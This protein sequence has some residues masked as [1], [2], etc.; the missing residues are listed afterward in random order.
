MRFTMNHLITNSGIWICLICML[1]L[2][3]SAAAGEEIPV[4]KEPPKTQEAEKSKPVVALLVSDAQ[5]DAD[6]LLPP[7]M[8]KLGKENEWEIV[9]LHGHGTADFP[10]FDVLEKTDVLIVYIR[11]LA[12][13]KEQLEKLK[14]YAKS[15]RGVIGL[16]TASH[17]FES[18][19]KIPEGSENW[20]EFDKEVL[21]G[22]YHNHGKDTVGSEVENV[23]E[24]ADSDILKGVGPAKWHSSGALYFTGPINE[25]AT[26]Y[27]YASSS[28]MP[29]TPLS[30]T[31]MYGKTRVAYTALGHQDD[32]EQEA[33]KTLLRNFVRW[34]LEEGKR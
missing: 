18:K 33:F 1:S 26:V 13:P 30:W 4:G 34:T 27:Q 31:R 22:N 28:E 32:F 20:P 12:L 11:R 7:L 2:A 19:A 23:P 14:K 16:R 29:K 17:A 24:L 10:N 5:Y 25:D 8:K 21:G 3:R 6:K 15:G 9:I